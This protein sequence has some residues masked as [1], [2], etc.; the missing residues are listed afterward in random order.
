MTLATPRQEELLAFIVTTKRERES[1]PSIRE[2]ADH[3]SLRGVSSVHRMLGQLE[4]AGYIRRQACLARAIQVLR[5]P[6][7]MVNT[8]RCPHCGG[9]V[10]SVSPDEPVTLPM[11]RLSDLNGS[12]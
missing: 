10:N 5:L 4:R 1:A 7:S 6:Q 8:L 9:A 3:F 11:A 2:M 12:V